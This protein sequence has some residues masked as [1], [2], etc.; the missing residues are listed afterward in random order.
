MN[1]YTHNPTEVTAIQVKKPIVNVQKK[2]PLA[3]PVKGNGGRFAYFMVTDPTDPLRPLRAHEFDWIIRHPNGVYEIQN[4]TQF[5]VNY[6]KSD[7]SA[8]D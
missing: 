2:V 7:D 5:Q 6:G 8:D 4:A 1:T 3:H